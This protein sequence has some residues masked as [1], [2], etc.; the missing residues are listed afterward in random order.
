MVNTPPSGPYGAKNDAVRID[1]VEDLDAVLEVAVRAFFRRLDVPHIAEE[2]VLPLLASGGS[3]LFLAIRDRPWPPWGLRAQTVAAA[4][5]V[6]SVSP[7]G[8]G[9]SPIY[10]ADSDATNIGLAAALYAEILDELTSSEHAEVN[11]LVLEGSTFAS[12]VLAEFGF[13]PS[14]DVLVTDEH[15]YVFHRANAATLRERLGMDRVSVPELL[16]H[17]TDDDTFR[18]QAL[19]LGTLQLASQPLRRGNRLVREISWIDGGLF[20]ASLPGGVGPV[21]IEG[22]D[23]PRV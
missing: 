5:Q 12:R 4:C 20:D 8:V 11:Y 16:A 1:R 13:A 18:Q 7:D 17:E 22:I 9:I 21:A 14:E 15:R 6:H 2:Q 10:L 23:E 3:S 19:F